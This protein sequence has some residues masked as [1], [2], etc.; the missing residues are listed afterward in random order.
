MERA[1]ELYI[2]A[3]ESLSEGDHDRAIELLLEA[4]S[5]NKSVAEIPRMLGRAYGDAGRSDEAIK[6][7]DEAL[8]MKPED[9]DILC[10]RGVLEMRTEGGWA[11]AVNYFD[12]SL[13][14]GQ[15]G[16]TVW[17]NK[18]TCLAY[19]EKHAE[20]VECYSKALEYEDDDPAIWFNK[21]LSLSVLAGGG[22]EVDGGNEI[23]SIHMSIKAPDSEKTEEALEAYL[24]VIDLDPTDVEARVNAGISLA[25]LDRLEEA[26]AFFRRALD[27]D[28]ANEQAQRWLDLLEKGPGDTQS[29]GR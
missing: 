25:W 10:D 12:R 22:V 24:K 13:A 4:R 1:R 3:C 18:A 19:M 9:P 15:D 28:E 29:R 5:L 27:I 21:G 16:G 17:S 11:R 2:E 6:W 7:M 23:V 20:A 26:A 14:A 8:E